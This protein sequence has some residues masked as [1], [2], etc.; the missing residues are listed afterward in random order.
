MRRCKRVVEHIK[1]STPAT[2]L[3]IEYQKEFKMPLLKVLQENNT[4]LWSILLMMER[5]LTIFNKI[6]LTLVANNKPQLILTPEDKTNMIAIVA[7][8]KPFKECGEELSSEKDV[9]ISLIIPYFQS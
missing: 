9:T 6:T 2:Y 7:L 3:L 4:T 8:L 5:I 1:S